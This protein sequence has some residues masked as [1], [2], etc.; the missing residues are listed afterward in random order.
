MTT[1]NFR[2]LY[3]PGE[4]NEDV[5]LNA[6]RVAGVVRSAIDVWGRVVVQFVAPFDALTL[7]SGEHLTP[8]KLAALRAALRYFGTTPTRRP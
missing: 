2:V 3:P 5:D 8:E 1:V 4:P 6:L 7:V